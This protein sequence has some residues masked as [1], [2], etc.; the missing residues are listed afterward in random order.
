MGSERLP[1]KKYYT[2]ILMGKETNWKT[3]KETDGQCKWRY[4]SKEV[5]CTTSNGSGVWQKQ[6]ETSSSSLIIIEMTEESRREK[7]WHSCM[8]VKNARVVFGIES[9]VIPFCEWCNYVVSASSIA[10]V[11]RV[12]TGCNSLPA[13]IRRTTVCLSVTTPALTYLLMSKFCLWL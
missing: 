2:A 13:D 1:E 12:P 6:M 7:R 5:E 11:L 8:H 10:S 9:Q 3:T 4:R